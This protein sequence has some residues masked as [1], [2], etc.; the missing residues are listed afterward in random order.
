MGGGERAAE[1][2]LRQTLSIAAALGALESKKDGAAGRINCA[3]GVGDGNQI[4]QDSSTFLEN[5]ISGVGF[6]GALLHLL[7]VGSISPLYV[8]QVQTMSRCL[9]L[10]LPLY[11]SALARAVFCNDWRIRLEPIAA[12]ACCML[13][14]TRVFL[15]RTQALLDRSKDASANRYGGTARWNASALLLEKVLNREYVLYRSY[16]FYQKEGRACVSATMASN[17]H[18]APRPNL[19]RVKDWQH[20]IPRWVMEELQKGQRDKRQVTRHNIPRLL[21]GNGQAP[22]SILFTELDVFVL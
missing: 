19:W 14:T 18:G 7:R 20:L 6:G 22:P 13:T 16:F 5:E 1:K 11:A 2:A 17:G 8:I 9:F 3:N 10:V 12:A 4:W 21:L 15:N